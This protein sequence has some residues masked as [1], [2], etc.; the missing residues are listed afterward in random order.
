MRARETLPPSALRTSAKTTI[1]WN[2]KTG[3]AVYNAIVWQDRRIR[4]EGD[5]LRLGVR[6]MTR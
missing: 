2:R 4:R 3:E 6:V 1:A 5:E